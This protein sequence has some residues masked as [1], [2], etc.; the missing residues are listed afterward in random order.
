MDTTFKQGKT[1]TIA[2]TGTAAT[3][4]A[5]SA[6]TTK[7]R[8]WATTNCFISIG[9]APT[10]TSSD[11][12]LTAGLPEVFDIVPGQKVSA[13]RIA[14]SGDIYVTSLSKN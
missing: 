4:A 7:V 3:I 11:M 10:A 12:P 2:Y 8:L 6:A 13:I 9:D 1:V 5:V 14:D